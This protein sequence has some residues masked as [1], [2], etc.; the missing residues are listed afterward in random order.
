MQ[1]LGLNQGLY[2][3]SDWIVRIGGC[4]T[5]AILLHNQVL[6][7]LSLLWSLQSPRQYFAHVYPSS[8]AGDMQAVADCARFDKTPMRRRLAVEPS[9]I[10]L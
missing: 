7:G 6:L 2:S 3:S 9:S 8:E 4:L 5:R 10:N 1:H